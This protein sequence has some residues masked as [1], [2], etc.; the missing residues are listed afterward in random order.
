MKGTRAAIGSVV[1]GAQ[2]I[3]RYKKWANVTPVRDSAAVI[4]LLA[5]QRGMVGEQEEGGHS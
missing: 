1:N 2:S 4:H 3:V 5:L